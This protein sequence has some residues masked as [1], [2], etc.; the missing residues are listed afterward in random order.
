MGKVSV[1]DKMLIEKLRKE[2]NGLKETVK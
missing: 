2:K 1:N